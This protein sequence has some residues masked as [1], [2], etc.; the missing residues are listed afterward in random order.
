MPTPLYQ[1]DAFAT[2]PFAGNPA[3]VCLLRDDRDADWMQQ[4]AAEMNV[5]ETAFLRPRGEEATYQLRWFTPT[6][7]VALCGHATLASAHV[8]WATDHEAARPALH[9]ETASGRLTARR[10][11]G[12][13]WMDFPADPVAPADPPPPTSQCPRRSNARGGWMERARLSRSPAGRGRRAGPAANP[14]APTH[15]R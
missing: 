10:D 5:S 4:V 3:A 2:V 7:E 12:W 6:D 1:V 14:L 9:F 11:D 8:L 13:I 15:P